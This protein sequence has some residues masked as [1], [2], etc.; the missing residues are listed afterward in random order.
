MSLLLIQQYHSKVEE[1]MQYGGSRNETAIRP[2][3]QKLLEQYCA[4]K[5][6]ELILELEYRTALGTI[7]NPDG[8]LKDAF[9]QDW[10][11]WESKDQKDTLDDE[12]QKKLAKGYPTTNILFEDGRTAV[13][14]R[15]GRELQRASFDDHAALD[16][17]IT[18]FV[19][20]EPQEVRT[21]REAIERFKE[22]LPDLVLRLRGLIEDQA[23]K[24]DAFTN[25]R[26]DFLELCR[27][28]INPHIVMADIRE[29]IIQHILTEDI[30]ITVFN[31]SQFHRENNIARSLMGMI[32][33][34]F[35]G[36]VRRGIL[37]KIDPY[38][39]IIKAAASG[40]ADHHEKQRFLKAFYENFYRAYNP[41]AADRLGIIY[42][43]NEI[44]RFM[45][46]SAE[47]LVHENFGR[48]LGDKD[49]E[50]LDPV[51]G[52]GTY[53]TEIIEHLPKNRLPFKYENEIH[54][55]EVAILPYYIANLNIEYT[56]SQKMGRYEEFKNICF[57]DTLDN[58]GFSSRRKYTEPESLDFGGFSLENLERI[59]RQ[60]TNLSMF[61]LQNVWWITTSTAIPSA[62][63]STIT[64]GRAHAETIS[65]TGH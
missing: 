31:E 16:S 3:F 37:G 19:N 14:I 51:T 58:L 61:W 17:L 4:D 21:F 65:P 55:N 35:T 20:Y 53:I 48:L 29:M 41:A 7:V 56:Y 45:V 2:A 30:F 6:I 22:D 36:D 9:R 33:T 40:I 13:L 47:H 44:V 27:D 63:P 52:T 43:P 38:I 59:K 32:E 26:E 42:T 60:Q 24:N 39:R 10:G 25:A 64:T 28:S 23:V 8:T 46:E 5:K 11:Y 34:F 12:I 1:I 62:S 18:T 57:V 50:I 54:C 49:V 15:N